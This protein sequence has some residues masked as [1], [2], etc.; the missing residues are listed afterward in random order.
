MTNTGLTLIRASLWAVLAA[1]AATAVWI[2]LVATFAPLVSGDSLNEMVRWWS[3]RAL[4]GLYYGGFIA[5]VAIVP[6]ILVFASWIVLTK[7]FS[8]L[9]RTRL[10]LVLASFVLALPF[11]A[12]VFASY[13]APTGS[14][15][16]FWS[17]ALEALPWV[18]LS[19]WGGILLP[20]LLVHSLEPTRETVAA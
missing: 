7:R 19:T 13:A 17:E 20:R 4:A 3:T 11:V 9:E 12:V 5:A 1:I 14:L 15:G 6:H 16:P 10:R 18:L 8:H 2:V